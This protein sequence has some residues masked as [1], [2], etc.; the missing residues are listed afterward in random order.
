M[1]ADIE[2]LSE[3][4]K[5]RGWLYW[6]EPRPQRPCPVVVMAHGFSCVKEQ[7]LDRY[8]EVF[9][10][11]GLAVLVYDHAHF[12]ASE[13]LPRQEVD[14]VRQRRG[15][16]DAISYAQTLPGLDARRIGLWG[17]SYSGGHVLQVA[18]HDRRVR[19]VVSQVPTISGY[20]SGLRRIRADQLATSLARLAEDRA[21]RFKGAPPGRIPAT[22]ADPATPCAM[23]GADCHAFFVATQDFAPTW[24]NEVTLRSLELARDNEP[25]SHVARISPTPLLM[26]VAE[27]DV[28]TATALCLEAY[29]RALPPKHLL[30]LPGG[31]FDPY[32]RYFARSSEAAC[33]WFCQHLLDDYEE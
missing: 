2:F 26:I 31:H 25:G 19:C 17:T 14:P 13:G 7:Y 24:R 21:A 32:V 15:Y 1:R 11:A 5:L 28:L 30:L 10:A 9:A 4:L 22:S 20:Q 18:A 29:Q 23:A 3:G 6:P 33:A 8:A 12:G 27:Q 16:Q